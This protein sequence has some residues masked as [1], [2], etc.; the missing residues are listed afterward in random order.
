VTPCEN[1]PFSGRIT[2]ERPAG[3]STA[4]TTSRSATRS[5]RTAF[6][7]RNETV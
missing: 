6:E 5:L 2:Y 1:G 4:S 7:F 3:R